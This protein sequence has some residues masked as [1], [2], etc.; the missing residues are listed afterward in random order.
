MLKIKRGGPPTVILPQS[1]SSLEKL[2]KSEQRS[3]SP[4]GALRLKLLWGSEYMQPVAV[5]EFLMLGQQGA[6]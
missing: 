1:C 6:T 4:A 5:K 3:L 2:E